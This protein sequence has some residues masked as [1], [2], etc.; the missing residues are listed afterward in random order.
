MVAHPRILAGEIPWTE[1]TWWVTVQGVA[2]SDDLVT[3]ILS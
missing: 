3:A 2:E 1:E